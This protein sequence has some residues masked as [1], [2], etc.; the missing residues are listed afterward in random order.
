M[1]TTDLR[2]K[3]NA[4]AAQNAAFTIQDNVRSQ[5]DLL[6]RS[7]RGG[8]CCSIAVHV[9]D[10]LYFAFPGTFADRAIGGMA[11]QHVF[12]NP[13]ASCSD[14]GA[15]QRQPLALLDRTIAGGDQTLA[16]GPF[17]GSQAHATG[18]RC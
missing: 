13:A 17:F 4:A 5:L 16:V 14:L 10:F 7:W 8:L 12:N 1:G 15:L 11:Q 2:L 9:D 18:C 3:A 6:P